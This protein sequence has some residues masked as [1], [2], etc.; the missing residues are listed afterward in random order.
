MMAN[1]TVP[2]HAGISAQ[3]LLADLDELAGFGARPDGGVDR[4]AGSAAD[5]AAREWLAQRLTAAG[6]H[7]RTDRAGNVL[8]RTH[9]GTGPWV[10]VGSHT[11]T[12]PAGGR[13]D[14]AYGVIAALE[15]LRT[16]AAVGHPAADSLEIVSF[17]DEEGAAPDSPGGLIGSTALCAGEHVHDL[18]AYVE[19]HIEQGPRM[20]RAG[21]DLATV[22]GIVGIDRYRVDV[23]GETNHAGT[24][25]M[26]LR[27][28]ACRAAARITARI[29]ELAQRTDP[30]MVA[31]VGCFEVTP[32]APNV[33]PGRAEL[34][35]EFRAGAAGS[36]DVVADG[37]R[38]LVAAVTRE[39][40]CHATVDRL[41]RK[42]VVTF[43]RVVRDLIE[44]ACS[45][46][47][48]PTGRMWSFAGHDASVLGAHV[49]TGMMFV[50][51]TG[52]IS[53]APQESTPPD[54]LVLGCQAL[55]DIVVALHGTSFS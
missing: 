23:R 26:D 41:S 20:E 49:P 40:R 30:A 9:A 52:G 31:N 37:L 38:A 50:P 51:S 3:R 15:V 2:I 53:H 32:G 10:L 13:L 54:Q 19:M 17:W 29:R 1:K 42:P 36:L 45:G 34:I 12:V 35:I 39:E 22:D 46:T 44:K 43:D 5:L 33:I 25:P 21:Q 16:L 8:G 48:R 27:A 24:T 55:C 47:G 6:L 7:A 11:D 28:D 18:R 14:G 4:V